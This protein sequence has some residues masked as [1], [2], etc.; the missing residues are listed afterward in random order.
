[1]NKIFFSLLFLAVIFFIFKNDRVELDPGIFISEAPSQTKIKSPISFKYKEF[2]ITPLAKFHI[3][4]KVLSRENY[5]FDEESKLSPLDLALGWQSMSNEDVVKHIDI[6]QSSRW[7]WFKWN[8]RNL[9]ISERDIMRQSANMHIIPADWSVERSLKDVKEGEII[10][11]HG[12]L[13]EVNSKKGWK[14]RSSLTRNDT[15]SHSCEVFYVESIKKI[16]IE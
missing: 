13:V 2:I 11:L 14:W 12:N 7:L 8:V 6:S 15:G 9:S 10:E 4:A 1:M 16:I 3:K 5:S